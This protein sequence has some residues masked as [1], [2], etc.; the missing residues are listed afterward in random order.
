MPTFSG[1]ERGER[2]VGGER[3]LRAAERSKC[4]GLIEPDLFVELT[5]QARRAIRPG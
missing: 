5:R 2:M 3:R 4:P 1:V